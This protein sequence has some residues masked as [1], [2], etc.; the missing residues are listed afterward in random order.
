VPNEELAQFLRQQCRERRLS[1]RSLSINAGLSPGTVHNI[2][3]RGYQPTLFSLNRL[4]DYLGVKREYLWQR[5][6]LLED[7][8]YD[9]ETFGDPRLRFH[10]ARVDK[11][12]RA[13]RNLIINLIESIITF[14]ERG[15]D[16]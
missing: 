9:D 7:M 1:L 6:G 8:D 10:F 14:L 15:R 13:A 4:A 2:I 5:A 11:L 12:P 16:V 3:N